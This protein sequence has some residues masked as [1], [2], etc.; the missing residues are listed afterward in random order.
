MFLS[1]FCFL[2]LVIVNFSNRPDV[3]K[4]YGSPAFYSE[5]DLFINGDSDAYKELN[6]ILTDLWGFSTA[7]ASI[8]TKEEVKVYNNAYSIKFLGNDVISSLAI[9]N[10]DYN[11][12]IEKDI[13]EVNQRSFPRYEF[14]K[15]IYE[16]NN[17]IC[18][19]SLNSHTVICRKIIP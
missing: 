14:F 11:S 19:I 13:I 10:E 7:Q 12:M 1:F 2:T 8:S 18:T 15:I 3:I 16:D 17:F 9:S 5:K 6:S 4:S